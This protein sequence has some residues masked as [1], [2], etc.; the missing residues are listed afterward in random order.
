LRGVRLD[1][2]GTLV[3]AS[4]VPMM[5]TFRPTGVNLQLVR[6]VRAG[7][8]AADYPA[9]R[10]VASGGFNA[11]KIREFEADSAPVDAYAV[12]SAFFDNTGMY[13]FTADI[14]ALHD[15]DDWIE[16]HKVGRP[17]RPNPRLAPV[18]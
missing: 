7:L 8:D 2:S 3:D 5:G 18:E 6:N 11:E 1:T 4:I 15:G 14:V 9:V 16:C 10:I 13:D 12:G 17:E